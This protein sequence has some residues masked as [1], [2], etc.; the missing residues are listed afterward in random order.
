VVA[1]LIVAG[2][3][4]DLVYNQ[5]RQNAFA[6][7]DTF[8]TPPTTAQVLAHQRNFVRYFSF[9]HRQV[10]SEASLAAHG[11]ADLRPFEA[12]RDMLEPNTG[13][14]WDLPSANGYIT[15]KLRHVTDVLGDH[16]RLGLADTL[17]AGSAEWN[18][19]LALNAVSHV[20]S[21]FLLDLPLLS[22]D[23]EGIGMVFAL[24]SPL[25]RAYVATRVRLAPSPS[26]QYVEL[27]AEDFAPGRDVV[28]TQGES[29]GLPAGD[30]AP[31][32]AAPLGPPTAT[33][34][35]DRQTLTEIDV[36]AP[37]GGVVVLA[38]SYFPAWTATVD[39]AAAEIYLV[40][41][42]QRGV[43]VAP[44]HHRVRFALSWRSFRVAVGFA[45]LCFVLLV[46]L[47]LWLRR[48]EP[49]RVGFAVN[50]IS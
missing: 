31:P 25:P 39:D 7:A 36:D 15:I 50:F 18:R 35:E 27:L 43:I 26:T 16:N 14:F 9:A 8:M 42:S 6:D 30:I 17:P 33:I 12:Q 41:H 5:M 2:T 19:I 29:G 46:G 21:P 11:W 24:P 47:W 22:P 28:F 38:D 45:V 49:P 20:V 34:V 13:L 40:N 32:V 3:L 23:H 44:G 10:H 1:W 48:R 4:G 37:G